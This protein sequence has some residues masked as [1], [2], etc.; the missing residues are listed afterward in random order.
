MGKPPGAAFI[1]H[2]GGFAGEEE[3][4]ATAFLEAGE[5]MTDDLISFLWDDGQQR[6]ML[7]AWPTPIASVPDSDGNGWIYVGKQTIIFGLRN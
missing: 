5:Q 3:P 1:Y 2:D 4:K 6:W 7:T